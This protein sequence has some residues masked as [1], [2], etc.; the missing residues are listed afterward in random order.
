[1]VV[2]I[3]RS[4]NFISDYGMALEHGRGPLKGATRTE[5]GTAEE[6]GHRSNVDRAAVS[7]G[8]WI[9]PLMRMS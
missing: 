6:S 5:H 2:I 8:T 9:Y 3:K 1:M 7:R 4:P